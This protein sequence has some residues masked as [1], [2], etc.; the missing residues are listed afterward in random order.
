MKDKNYWNKLCQFKKQA[1]NIQKKMGVPI[2]KYRT[3]ALVAVMLNPPK[4]NCN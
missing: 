4:R 3:T 2:N 1:H